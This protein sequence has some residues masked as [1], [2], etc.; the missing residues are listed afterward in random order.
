MEELKILTTLKEIKA[1]SDPY[2]MIIM[3][4]YYTLAK[5]ATVKQIADCMGEVPA[6]VHYHFKKLESVGILVLDHTEEINGIIAKYYE[7]T[8]KSFQIQNNE[9]GNVTF[10]NKLNKAE[11]KVSNTYDESKIVF[12]NNI[13]KD[14]KG[15]LNHIEMNEVELT[16][17]E[18][19]EIIELIKSKVNNKKNTE[20]VK[21]LKRFHV[22]TSIVETSL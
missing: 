3:K 8:A 6:K 16:E 20:Q 1:F 18:Y 19:H 7:P 2:R 14:D 5:P 12:M 4:H 15:V 13:S 11:S 22:F 21:G 9:I 17:S 10:N